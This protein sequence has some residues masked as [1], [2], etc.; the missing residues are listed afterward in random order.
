MKR[1]TILIYAIL[2][3][4]ILNGQEQ[5]LY[6]QFFYNKLTYNAGFSGAAP[7]VELT[8]IV[9][10]QWMGIKGS[11]SIQTIQANIPLRPERVGI[12]AVI[13]RQEV[14]LT[15]QLNFNLTYAYHIR[16]GDYLIGIG[17]NAML[18]SIRN[19]FS[20]SRIR[21][22]RPFGQDPLLQGNI[23]NATYF[24][25]GAAVLLR[26]ERLY[27]GFSVPT[28]VKHHIEL[29][30]QDDI[31]LDQRARYWHLMA[32]YSIPVGGR[33]LLNPQLLLSY[34]S[35]IPIKLDLNMLMD[36]GDD[37]V[38]GIGYRSFSGHE[39]SFGESISLLGGVKVSDHWFMS[40]SY[41]IGLSAFRQHH[42]GS[43]EVALAIYFGDRSRGG[44]V[45]SPR[46]F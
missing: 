12:G 42:S 38:A 16:Y 19:D 37:F 21:T 20:E 24:N 18:G 27:A 45:R 34:S 9:R 4:F 1:F 35:G 31:L 39:P 7:G 46:F 22:S 13:R 14:G 32:G 25:A 3:S 30:D 2:F 44:E 11:P 17:V 6:T 36:I 41:D 43:I 26:N 10:E 28:I 8:G 33:L 5:L 40:I 23:E 29:T 15:E